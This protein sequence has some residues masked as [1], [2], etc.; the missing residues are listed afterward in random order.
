[1][2][3]ASGRLG[4][5]V[6]ERAL[7]PVFESLYDV[8]SCL[9]PRTLTDPGGSS[10]IQSGVGVTAVTVMRRGAAGPVWTQK[11]TDE[12]RVNPALAVSTYRSSNVR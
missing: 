1:M 8:R 10:F 12:E 7:D 6:K 9:V 2:G 3:V 4:V 5:I 11:L